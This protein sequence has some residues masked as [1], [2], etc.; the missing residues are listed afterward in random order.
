[1]SDDHT[2][3]VMAQ[4][5]FTG[6]DADRERLLAMDVWLDRNDPDFAAKLRIARMFAKMTED[7]YDLNSDPPRDFLVESGCAD[8]VV[9]HNLWGHP[10]AGRGTGTTK[11]SPLHDAGHWN[12]R[13]ASTMARYIFRFGRDFDAEPDGYKRIDEP[14]LYYLTVWTQAEVQRCKRITLS[15]LAAA[16]LAQ[17][18]QLAANEVLDLSHVSAIAGDQLAA[19]ASM[20]HLRDLLLTGVPAADAEIATM[21]SSGCRGLQSLYLDQTPAGRASLQALASCSELALLSLDD[22]FV[23][24]AGLE[25]LRDL[26]R[27]ET[28]SLVNTNITDADVEPLSTLRNL[29][30]LAL[31]GSR[32]SRRGIDALA[33]ALPKCTIDMAEE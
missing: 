27:L 30:M 18:K 12:R 8:I 19:I 25:H 11:C 23:G 3:L 24:G 28:L 17:L 15:D 29:R 4:I 10:G 31:T 26:P 5:G 20:P 33:H 16:R 21:L 6:S 1:M 9:I 22:T 2:R 13:L 14:S 32:I 7:R